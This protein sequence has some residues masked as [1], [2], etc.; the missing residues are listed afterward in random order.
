MET[1][2]GKEPGIRHCEHHENT[3]HNRDLR[4]DVSHQDFRH[5]VN[6]GET[7]RDASSVGRRKHQEDN[8]SIERRDKTHGPENTARQVATGV[9]HLT[10]NS[11][12]FRYT[13]VGNEDES[14]SLEE[15]RDTI[16]RERWKHL[17]IG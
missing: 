6:W 9:L 14:D 10:S 12:D 11:G 2:G 4:R 1:R 16:R 13:G 17:R 8:G 15:P 7:V 5:R 3:Q